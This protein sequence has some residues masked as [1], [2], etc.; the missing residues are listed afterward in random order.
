[1]GDEPTIADLSA[2]YE[3]QFLMFLG[4]DFAKWE[5][6]RNWMDRMSN[7]EEVRTANSA[8]I[9]VIKKRNPSAK[10]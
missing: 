9:K 5:R 10:L 7:I 1:M 4:E 6:L 2:F 8:F 3:I